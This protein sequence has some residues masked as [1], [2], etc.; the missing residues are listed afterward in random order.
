MS[1][2]IFQ[3]EIQITLPL[4]CSRSQRNALL[5]RV[6]NTHIFDVIKFYE[7]RGGIRFE[8]DEF[9]GAVPHGRK[10]AVAGYKQS[11]SDQ[12][13]TRRRHKLR[14]F[15]HPKQL[16]N[17]RAEGTVRNVVQGWLEQS[18]KRGSPTIRE[19]RNYPYHDGERHQRTQ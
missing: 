16:L 7:H 11:T 8:V 12:T 13:Q 14:T 19:R 5:P 4:S 18:V 1:E 2:E 17:I 9:N 3:S 10:D 6:G 15:W